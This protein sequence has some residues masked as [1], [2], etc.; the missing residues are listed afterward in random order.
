MTAIENGGEK[1]DN[2]NGELSRMYADH[3][4]IPVARCAFNREFA[5]SDWNYAEFKEPDIIFWRHNGESA[6]TV[7]SKIGSY[8]VYDFGKLPLFADYDSAMQYRDE[9]IERAKASQSG[10]KPNS[11]GGGNTNGETG[12]S[13]SSGNHQN[14]AINKEVGQDPDGNT[15]RDNVRNEPALP[16]ENIVALT[17]QNVN[18]G[19]AD[20]EARLDQ[21]S[22]RYRQSP[23]TRILEMV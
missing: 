13:G 23:D 21:S 7:A 17:N 10:E 12:S 3:G 6:E 2:F 18:S 1:L 15:P 16:S 22:P 20:S 11:S 4:F 8:P 19:N 5:P 14:Q 9:Q